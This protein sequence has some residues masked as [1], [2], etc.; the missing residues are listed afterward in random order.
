M[1][2][3]RRN[4]GYT[5]WDHKRDEDIL[6]EL[7]ISQITEFLYQYRKNWKEHVDRMS[8]D[9]IPKN[10]SKIST[11]KEN[12]FRKTFEKM[13]GFSFVTRVTGLNRPNTGKEDD[14]DDDDK[15]ETFCKVNYLFA[16]VRFLVC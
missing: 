4:A 16:S 8:C 14:F 15:N 6:T 3:L 1:H 2:F 12:K 5:R 10:D 11:K 7:Q 9:R 13:E